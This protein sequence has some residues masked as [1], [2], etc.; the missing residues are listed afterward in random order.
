[1]SMMKTGT[2]AGLIAPSGLAFPLMALAADEVNF[3]K[4][5]PRAG[6]QLKRDM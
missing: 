1:M 2:V 5:E 6:P 3:V 4:C